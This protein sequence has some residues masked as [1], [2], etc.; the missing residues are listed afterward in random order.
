MQKDYPGKSQIKRQKAPIIQPAVPNI[1]EEGLSM[2]FQQ[3][4]A[5]LL[6]GWG[7]VGICPAQPPVVHTHTPLRWPAQ[8][9]VLTE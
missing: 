8:G 3:E 5:R 4:F 6:A 9:P 7:S 1:P 2:R